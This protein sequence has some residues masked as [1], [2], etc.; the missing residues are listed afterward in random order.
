[1]IQDVREDPLVA[2]LIDRREHTARSVI[3]LIGGHL[4]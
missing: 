3:E 1:V 4:A 2:A